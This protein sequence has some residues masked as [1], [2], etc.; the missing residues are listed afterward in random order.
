MNIHNLSGQS[1]GQYEL[2]GLLGKG[3]MGAV[4]QAYQSSLKRIVAIKVMDST[5]AEQPGFIERFNREAETAAALEHHHIIPI[6]DY[7]NQRS[8]SYVV[9]RLLTGGSLAQRV[10]KQ[11]TG[12]REGPS[13][14]EVVELLK[15][16]ASALD[17][18]HSRG[19][20]HRD[21][22]PGNIMFDKHGRGYL[23]DFGIA[24]LAD[25]SRVITAPGVVLGTPHYMAPEQWGSQ[26]IGPAADQYALAVVTYLLVTGRT[27]FQA[28]TP[29]SFMHK[30]LNELPT[31]AGTLRPDLPAG[32]T[33][34]LERALAKEPAGRFPTVTAFA[35]AFERAVAGQ[36]GE[37]SGFF[38]V[39]ARP[40]EATV[41]PWAASSQG[42]AERKPLFKRPLIPLVGGLAALLVVILIGAFLIRAMI[43]GGG[44]TPA[45][46]VGPVATASQVET[47]RP[48]ESVQSTATSVSPQE[49]VAPGALPAS[50]TS[51]PTLP[52]EPSLIPASHPIDAA[53]APQL[54]ML[55][56]M[57]QFGAPTG[58]AMSPDGRLL[59]V[60]THFDIDVYDMA[61]LGTPLYSLEGHKTLDDV[62]LSPD[63]VMLASA[64]SSF[65]NTIRLWDLSRGGVEKAVLTGHTDAVLGLAYSPDGA[66]IASASADKSVRIWD[67]Q[68][69]TE[70][71]LAFDHAQRVLSVAFSPDGKVLASG[72]DD[73]VVRLWD[74]ETGESLNVLETP[75]YTVGSVAFSSDGALLASAGSYSQE[76]RLWNAQSGEPVTI[77]H[78]HAQEG[79]SGGVHSLAFAP[80]SA[81]LASG[82][83]DRSI[84]IWN[85]DQ[86]APAF[87]QELIV[88]QGHSDWV[89]GLLFSA[90][91]SLLVSASARDGT[92][93]FWGVASPE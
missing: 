93:R 48:V 83:G 21:I 41:S 28:D 68:T 3:G 30:H 86:A 4:Y 15:Q 62:A 25:A 36:V 22:K 43:G 37:P 51:A 53:N 40:S 56:W 19:V 58:I 2:R 82:G 88:L 8:I 31:P 35:Q 14:G 39:P 27:P 89:D 47:T 91:G 12:K 75:N 76:I 74:V 24:Q 5:L 26:E 66:K 67:A 59:V 61:D 17:Y 9:M 71:F 77:L 49:T 10:A 54:E 92:V 42:A 11:A 64:G 50:P 33:A 38:S 84:R 63:G 46:D 7:G 13:M 20:V 57:E 55:N 1:L 34:V 81:L 16:L 23:V 69:G 52:A 6:Y 32:I 87:G 70:L 90:D 65:D 85:A 45:A 72:G 73:G 80:D 79:G 18:A 78:G 60:G 29:L 44:E